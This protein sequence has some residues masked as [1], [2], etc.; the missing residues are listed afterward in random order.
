[1]NEKPKLKDRLNLMYRLFSMLNQCV[2]FLRSPLEGIDENFLLFE[3][4]PLSQAISKR[5]LPLS[6]TLDK[7]PPCL[8]GVSSNGVTNIKPV[9]RFELANGLSL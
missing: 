7:G 8:N 1:M 3:P 5:R 2:W 4:R 9:S 6:P